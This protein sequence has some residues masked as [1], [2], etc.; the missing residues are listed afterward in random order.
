MSK[1]L[2]ATI[3]WRVIAFLTDFFV[4]FCITGEY[5]KA[6]IVALVAAI[7]KTII[8]YFWYKNNER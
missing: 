3:E 8:F 1:T 4:V 2:R 7:S 6:W 5:K